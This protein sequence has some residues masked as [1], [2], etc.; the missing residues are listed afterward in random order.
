MAWDS[1]IRDRALD[2]MSRGWPLVD[3]GEKLDVPVP[4]LKYWKHKYPEL[5]EAARTESTIE[6]LQDQLQELSRK[7]QSMA[8]AHKVAMISKSIERLKK[9]DAAQEAKAKSRPRPRVAIG[10][11][12]KKIREK[13]PELL[14][15]YPFQKKFFMS[16]AQ[17]RVWLKG[18]QL[19]A[20]RT[21]GADALLAARAGTP[22]LFLSA[23]EE[24]SIILTRYVKQHAEKLGIAVEGGDKELRVE[25]GANIKAMAHNWR[26]VQGFTGDIWMDE[27]AWYSNPKRMW[28]VFVPSIGAI[29]GRLTIM[30]T[31]FEA[32]GLF[33]D[34]FYNEEKYFMFE[35]FQT[36][37]HDAI[38]DGMPFDLEVMRALFDDDTWALMYECQFADD[39]NAF[40]PIGLIKG[41][42]NYKHTLYY[43]DR[44]KALYAGYDIG[45][46]RDLSVLAA[47]DSVDDKLRLAMLDVLR[48]APFD[49]QEHTVNNFMKMFPNAALRIDKTGLGMQLAENAVKKFSGRAFGIH[50]TA[51]TKE[52]MALNFRRML[53][54]KILVLPNDP[55]LIADIHAIKRRA[56]QKSFLY[57]ADRN[58]HGHADRFW[59][60]ALA[61]S[62]KKIDTIRE[63]SGGR[64]WI[65]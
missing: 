2:L 42:V 35:R 64:A 5:S 30:S 52:A 37:I 6:N 11:E 14:G 45:R 20:S 33:H 41:C 49:E 54:R 55:V 18:R 24:Q 7:E 13:T 17:F 53:E 48:K 31:P 60:L 9:L 26:T 34:I 44:E 3:I 46:T 51:A 22:Q 61:A 15:F 38:A 63:N 65:L 58:E 47:L 39:E 16:D 25:G 62:H 36:T 12:V 28:S 50:F 56:G 1:R 57:D 21:A 8:T 23:S 40:Y 43:P 19:G 27:F 32:A 4:T 29:K 59:A 10:H